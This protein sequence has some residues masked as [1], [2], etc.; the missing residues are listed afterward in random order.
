MDRKLIDYLP[1]FIQDYAE[2]KAIMDAGQAGVEKA[3]TD[4]ENVMHDQFIYDATENGIRRWESLLGIKPKATDTMEERK[5]NIL[6]RMN[7]QLPY[8]LEMLKSILSSMCGENGYSVT[9]DHGQYLLNVKLSLS[10][11]NNVEAVKNLLERMVPANMVTIVS[12]FNTH[13]ILADFTHE[14][15]RVYTQ[16]QVR[17]ETLPIAR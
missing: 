1:V 2:I 15:L 17:E 3:W 14:Q 9:P 4:T 10:N 6:V 8:T 12:L 11:E 5:F 7:E 16:K 13:G